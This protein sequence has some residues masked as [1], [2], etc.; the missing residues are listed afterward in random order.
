[1]KWPTIWNLFQINHWKLSN[2]WYQPIKQTN[3]QTIP[4]IPILVK[5]YKG[6]FA[7]IVGPW[8]STATIE[9]S[10][11]VLFKPQHGMTK[12]SRY[13]GVY[14]STGYDISIWYQ[15]TDTYCWTSHSNQATDMY[16]CATETWSATKRNDVLSFTGEQ[17]ELQDTV[18]NNK[19]Q[20]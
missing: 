12:W 7:T 11:E 4:T 20:A 18:L 14:I 16:R 15:C 8:S 2:D 6:S 17:S 13:V 5:I 10:M 3:L 19:G 1:M 9:I